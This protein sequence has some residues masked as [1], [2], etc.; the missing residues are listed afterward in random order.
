MVSNQTGK[1]QA[2]INTVVNSGTQTANISVEL[3]GSDFLQTVESQLKSIQALNLASIYLDLP[4]EHET[5]STAF[6]DLEK[7][8]FSG[9]LGCRTT[10]VKVM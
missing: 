4:I 3:I 5:A 2:I 9:D 6:E 10:Q 8:G 7:Y 1:G